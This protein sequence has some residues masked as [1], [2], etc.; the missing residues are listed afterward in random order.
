MAGGYILKK[1][2]TEPFNNNFTVTKDMHASAN[3]AYFID[4]GGGNT[5]DNWGFWKITNAAKTITTNIPF[6]TRNGAD[7]VLYTETLTHDSVTWEIIHGWITSGIFVI[8]VKQLT[9]AQKQFRLQWSGDCGNISP[10]IFFT[11]KTR[12]D[13]PVTRYITSYLRNGSGVADNMTT[14]YTQSSTTVIPYDSSL[15]ELDQ[16]YVTYSTSSDDETGETIALVDGCTLVI[17]W[18]KVLVADLQ[19]WINNMIDLDYVRKYLVN[20][21]ANGVKK[22]GGSSWTKIGD[23]P[24]TE[25]MFLTHGHDNIPTTSRVGLILTNPE[26]LM[27]TDRPGST[28]LIKK[29]RQTAIPTAKVVKQVVNYDIPSGIKLVTATVNLSGTSVLKFAVSIDNAVTWK[30]WTGSAWVNVNVDNMS[31]F[32]SGGM[33]ATVMNAI[34][35]A[36][37]AA[38]TTGPRI[39]FAMYFKRTSMADN[40]NIDHLRIDWI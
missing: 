28:N 31:Q 23:L 27:Y 25:A 7:G 12:F 21:G 26:L 1:D 2:W 4:G 5:F 35:Q 36:Q 6:S 30:S 11:V 24:V 18:G 10:G 32:E 33:T 14:T 22:W 38:L 8:K 37:W 29:F 39:R 15:M 34:T 16:E 13:S 40:C 20:D 19:T 3:P 9:G 17:N